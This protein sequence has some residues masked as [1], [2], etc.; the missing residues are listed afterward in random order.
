[1]RESILSS[2]QEAFRTHHNYIRS[3]LHLMD[4][5]TLSHTNV[6]HITPAPIPL[7]DEKKNLIDLTRKSLT[8][9]AHI[10]KTDQH[11]SYASTSWLPVKTYY[12]LF[13]LM[14]T[15]EYLFTLDPGS[16]KISHSKCATRFTTRL[17]SGEI[18]FSDPKLNRIYDQ[19]IFTYREPPGTNLRSPFPADQHAALAMKKIARYKLE[20]WQR[21]RRIPSFAPQKHR[22]Q[23]EEFLE[24]FRLSIFDFPY[25]MRLR[26]SYRDF[27]FI[28]GVSSANTAAYFNDYFAF[29]RFFFRALR[30]LKDQLVRAR[31]A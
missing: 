29:S 9:E 15:I 23:K 19:T 18:A 11:Y 7:L 28:E 31:T 10:V 20:E 12:L 27:A 24:K 5:S 30:G 17:A 1:M 26:A 14:M 21:Q 16:F 22:H 2:G 25:Y 13:N 4:G 3:L 8:D 6:Q